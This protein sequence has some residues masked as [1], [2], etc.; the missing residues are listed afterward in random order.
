[1][2]KTPTATIFFGNASHAVIPDVIRTTTLRPLACPLPVQQLFFQNQVHKN[3]GLAITEET[4]KNYTAHL[5]HDSDYLI[6][7]LPNIGIGVLTADC[8]PIALIDPRNTAIAMIHA[9][10]RGS[11]G[12]IVLNALAHM[13]NLYGT[14]ASD[15]I[16]YIGP[17]A[18]TC[19]YQIDQTFVNQLPGWAHAFVQNN[20]FDLVAC[21]ST[22]LRQAGIP[23]EQINLN[24]STC[25][26]CNE[27]FLSYRR[28]S[29]NP[30]R[31]P[32]IIWLN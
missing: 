11:V 6:T 14:Q 13:N 3:Q 30:A 20:R 8:A 12:G 27:K 24:T 2:I 26:I 5:V 1:M 28:N 15:A 22:I 32:S 7:H 17:C 4:R 19:C 25:T 18:H 9:G 21:N 10:W 16:A 23:A 31:Q 29:L